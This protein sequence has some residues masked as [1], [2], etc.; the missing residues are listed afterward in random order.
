MIV[1]GVIGIIFVTCSC[2]CCKYRRLKSQYYERV[3]LLKGRDP[4]RG[5]DPSRDFQDEPN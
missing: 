1:V 5:S 2:V 3:N 4:G